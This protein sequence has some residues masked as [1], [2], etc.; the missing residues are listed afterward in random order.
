MDPRETTVL[1]RAG[2]THEIALNLG[3]LLEREPGFEWLI[4]NRSPDPSLNGLCSMWYHRVG[5][6]YKWGWP[7]HSH[8]RN[9]LQKLQ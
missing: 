4:K 6:L 2:T 3:P 1:Q 7:G 5:R 8:M 9:T